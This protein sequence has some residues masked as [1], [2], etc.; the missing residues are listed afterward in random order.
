MKYIVGETVCSRIHNK[1][2]VRN[3]DRNWD[4]K[5]CFLLSIMSSKQDVGRLR[6]EVNTK[7][8]CWCRRA[9]RPRRRSAP[10]PRR[11]ARASSRQGARAA[12]CGQEGS[13]FVYLCICVFVYLCICVFVSADRRV[14]RWL[15]TS[16]PMEQRKA[17]DQSGLPWD[18]C[19]RVNIS[20]CELWN[21]SIDKRSFL[22]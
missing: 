21:V 7:G 6:S 13:V 18:W 2:Y 14:S 8:A 19:P 10:G 20:S 22:Q 4:T 9:R 17:L 12:C 16:G 3:Q 15:E 11:P 5:N 1:D